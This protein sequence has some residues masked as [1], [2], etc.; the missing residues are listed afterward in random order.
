MRLVIKK[1]TP[2][3]NTFMKGFVLLVLLLCSNVSLSQQMLN[4]QNVQAY[5]NEVYRDCPQYATEEYVRINQMFIERI[6]VHSISLEEYPECPNLSDVA[7]KNKCNPDLNYDLNGFSPETFNPFKYHFQQQ[8]RESLYF[9][10]NNQPFI[11]EIKANITS[12]K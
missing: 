9:R 11:I 12:E 3:I 1:L 2:P 7:L 8:A 10:V 4:T 5:L 6:V